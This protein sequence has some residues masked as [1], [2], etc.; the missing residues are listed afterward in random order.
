MPDLPSLKPRQVARAL[1]RAGFYLVRQRGSH[2]QYKKGNLLVTLP[3]HPGDLNPSTL[4][5]I[6]RQAR[7]TPKELLELL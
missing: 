4:R 2:A 7:M 5:S 6:L 3:M 1:E